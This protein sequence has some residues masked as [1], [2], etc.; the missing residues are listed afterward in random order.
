MVTTLPSANGTLGTRSG[1]TYAHPPAS[2]YLTLT[3]N[4]DTGSGLQRAAAGQRDPDGAH[5]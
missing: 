5:Q 3:A 4:G 2:R 1:Q